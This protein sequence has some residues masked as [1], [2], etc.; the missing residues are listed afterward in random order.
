VS[1]EAPAG[2]TLLV[3]EPAAPAVPR[4]RRR[5]LRRFLTALGVLLAIL[6]AVVGGG[7]WYLTDRYAGNIDRVGGV[8]ADLDEEARP[9]PATPAEAVGA[10]PVTSCWSARTAAAPRT[11][12]SPRAGAPTP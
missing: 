9:A 6:V 5:G 3:D 12:A 2:S 11:R 1:D 7:L 10:E 8:F 4:R